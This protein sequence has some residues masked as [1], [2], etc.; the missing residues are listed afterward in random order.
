MS[1]IDKDGLTGYQKQALKA[2]ATRSI[3]GKDGMNDYQRCSKK[4][5]KTKLI[6]NT[7]QSNPLILKKGIEKG[8]RT[9]ERKGIILPRHLRH[10]RDCYRDIVTY[11]TNLVYCEYYNF[12]NPNNLKRGSKEYHL[13]HIYSVTKGLKDNIP[14]WVICHPCNLQMLSAFDNVSKSNRC[15]I[16]LEELFSR[17]EDFESKYI[18]KSR[19]YKWR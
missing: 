9:K 10:D 14:I 13:D 7:L 3:I 4:G 16:T 11:Y 6:N 8:L 12:I 19:R 15:D 17:I 1:Q 5:Q 2:K 18:V